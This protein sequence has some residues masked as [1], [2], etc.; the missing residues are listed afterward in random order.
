MITVYYISFI[1]G[2]IE[3]E[4]SIKNLPSF[5]R[6]RI[7]KYR[8]RRKKEEHSLSKLLLMHVCMQYGLD[9]ED[10]CYSKSG[11][12][13]FPDGTFHFSLSHSDGIVVMAISDDIIGIDVASTSFETSPFLDFAKGFY[14]VSTFTIEDWVATEA[15]GKRLGIGLSQK[16]YKRQE[17][18]KYTRVLSLLEN[19]YCCIACLP[20]ASIEIEEVN[21][22]EIY[23]VYQNGS[24]EIS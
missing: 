8:N 6:K 20:N 2:S 13:Y 21:I 10:I 11:K 22:Q 9:W 7:E 4:S 14:G 17:I 24:Y 1:P 18:R 19:I 5:F 16:D 3:I 12:P 15:Y 23:K